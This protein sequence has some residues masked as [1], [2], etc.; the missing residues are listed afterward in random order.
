MQT[1]FVDVNS[2]T[3]NAME[4]NNS[5]TYNLYLTISN[6]YQTYGNAYGPGEYMVPDSDYG[7]SFKIDKKDADIEQAAAWAERAGDYDS[8]NAVEKAL[9]LPDLLVLKGKLE[10]LAFACSGLFPNASIGLNHYLGNTGES[11][12]LS[13]EFVEEFLDGTVKRKEHV[14]KYKNAARNAVE[15]MLTIDKV[16]DFSIDESMP[17]S[18]GN[19][20][21]DWTLLIGNFH[22]SIKEVLSK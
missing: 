6:N 2:E 13:S 4:L 18:A 11:M 22:F 21:I 15:Y 8:M 7:A 14:E 17:L 10:V 9:K 16:A 20:N 19:S 5:E 12:K 3:W 1:G